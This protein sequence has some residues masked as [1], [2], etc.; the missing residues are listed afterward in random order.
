MGVALRDGIRIRHVSFPAPSKPNPAT[1]SSHSRS[2]HNPPKQNR[3]E[4]ETA[5]AFLSVNSFVLQEVFR[6]GKAVHAGPGF[7]DRG[8]GTDQHAL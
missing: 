4:D 8:K 1:T 7:H 6:Q 5:E 2:A 3:F